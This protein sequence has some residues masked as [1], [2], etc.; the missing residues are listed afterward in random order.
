MSCGGLLG[1]DDEEAN[2]YI[3]SYRNF[4][5]ENVGDTYDIVNPGFKFYMNNLTATLGL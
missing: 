2:E 1:T 3:C 5:R 4:G